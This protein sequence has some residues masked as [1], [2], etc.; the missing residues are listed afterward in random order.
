[1]GKTL[2]EKMKM[3]DRERQKKI[4]ARAAHLIAEEQTLRD[5]RQAHDLTQ[6]RMAE[7]LGVGQ[8]SISRLERRTDLLISTLRSYIEVM[9][10]QLHLVAE[11]PDR[12]PV[13][14]SGFTDIETERRENENESPK[15]TEEQPG[16]NVRQ[17]MA[18]TRVA[19]W[20]DQPPATPS[21]GDADLHARIWKQPDTTIT[22]RS[23][24]PKSN[25]N[26][27]T[28]KAA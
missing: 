23:R 18:D 17:R 22:S 20:T 11:F 25:T 8:D 3:L 13:V 4:N 7:H 16:S 2:N 12:P 5:L 14:L 26:S 1:M 9:G 28:S 21:S 15:K 10:G 24:T 19:V 27:P 6:A